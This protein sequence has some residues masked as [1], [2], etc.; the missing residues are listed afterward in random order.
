MYQHNDTIQKM[1]KFDL[2]VKENI[3]NITKFLTNSWSPIQNINNWRVWIWK[4]K[5][6]FNL[7]FNECCKIP[8]LLLLPCL[9]FQGK[10]NWKG[11][12]GYKDS[13][14]LLG[15]TKLAAFVSDV[16]K[17]CLKRQE[18]LVENSLF[19]WFVNVAHPFF[20]QIHIIWTFTSM[21][22]INKFIHSFLRNSLFKNSAIWLVVL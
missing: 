15:L 22:K 14:T 7:K 4:K 5:T 18:Q 3:N 16:N 11:G 21:K 19:N 17:I 8:G 2:V 13:P 12:R 20:D 1:I 10:T 9:S 6:L